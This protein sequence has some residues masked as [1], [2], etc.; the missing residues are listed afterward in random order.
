V[1]G[2]QNH[3]LSL[4]VAFSTQQLLFSCAK[5]PLSS[6]SGLTQLVPVVSML[7]GG[8]VSLMLLLSSSLAFDSSESR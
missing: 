7:M 5:P 2:H 1:N 6:S 3:P 4:S 8:G